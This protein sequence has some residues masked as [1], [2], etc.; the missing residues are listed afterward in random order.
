[1]VVQMVV[2]RVDEMGDFAVVDWVGK[3]VETLGWWD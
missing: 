1:M 2:W 3:L